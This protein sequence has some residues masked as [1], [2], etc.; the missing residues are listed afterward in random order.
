MTAIAGVVEDGKVWIGGDSAGVADY[1]LTLR[2]DE[3][4]FK[5]GPFLF[6]FTTSFRMGQLLRY[7]FNPPD[8]DPRID[9][10]K[11]LVTTFMDAVRDCLKNGGYASSSGGSEKGGT[12][13]LGYKGNLYSV[14]DDYQVGKAV[15]GINAVGCG[16]QIVKGALF[17]QQNVKPEKRIKLAL[18]AA[19]RFSS[20][21]RGPFLVLNNQ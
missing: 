1:S 11:Y 7:A 3:K 5:N 15:D 4:V 9:D 6:G 10:F 21:V 14:Y 17:V 2:A 12:F 8:H 20:G 13:L 16:E 19:E 18:T